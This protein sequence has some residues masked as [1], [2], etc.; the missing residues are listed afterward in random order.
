MQI[1]N[2][3]AYH[4]VYGGVSDLSRV[5]DRFSAGLKVLSLPRLVLHERHIEGVLQNRT[6]ACVGRH[7]FDHIT[8]H[9]LRGGDLV[10]GPPGAERRLRPG[11]ITVLDTSRPHVSQMMARADVISVQ[12]A[13]A[14]VREVLPDLTAVHGAILSADASRVLAEF[15]GSLTRR[16]ETLPADPMAS[17]ASAAIHLLGLAL[18]D[19]PA[20]ARALP[21]EAGDAL[22]RRRADAFI[23]E[24]LSDP[25]LDADAIAAAIGISRSVLYRIFNVDGGVRRYIQQR[26][27][28]GLRRALLDPGEGRRLSSLAHAYGFTTQSHF[29]RS[30]ATAFGLPPGQFRTELQRRWNDAD[31]RASREENLID[32]ARALY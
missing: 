30:F 21:A 22:R 28:N 15:L 3:D 17:L 23:A 7:G 31:A 9:L 11:Q 19:L 4:R 10:S 12:L 5:G 13:R 20:S 6:R 18:N 16:S 27:L 24:H 1:E 8:L 32:L 25:N 2:F 29:S 14:H 26:R